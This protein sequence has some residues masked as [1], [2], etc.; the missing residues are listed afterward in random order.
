MTGEKNLKSR[1][2]G[3]SER[4]EMEMKL[5][6]QKSL[7]ALKKLSVSHTLCASMATSHH[8]TLVELTSFC[9]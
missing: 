5:E 1:T 4:R 2:K 6:K 7:E 3:H 9:L 8:V